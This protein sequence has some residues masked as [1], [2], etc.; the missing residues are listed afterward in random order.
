MTAP[1]AFVVGWP[2]AHSRSPLIHRFWLKR[3]GIDGD[4]VPRRFRRRRSRRFSRVRREGLCRR[5]RDAAA[6]GGGVPRLRGDDAGRA[7]PGGGEHAV[8]RRR[9]LHGDNTDVYG[10]VANLDERAPEWRSGSTALVIGAGG[11]SR[12][13]LQALID[14]G[15]SPIVVLNRTLARAEALARHFG[16][17]VS[18]GGLD[19]LPTCSPTRTSSSTRR[20]PACRRSGALDIPWRAA[21]KD[22]IAT[23]LVYVPLVT[24][25]LHGA[26]ERGLTIVDGLGMLL[27]QAVPGFERWFGVRPAV[28]A[29][30]RAHVVADIEG[31]RLTCASSASPDRSAWAR[32]RPPRCSPR[33]ACRC[34]MRTRPCIASIAARRSRRSRRRFRASTVDG[35]VDRARLAERVVGD[36][37]ALARLEAIVHPLVRESEEAFLAQRRARGTPA[38]RSSTSRCSSR[39]SA[40]DRVDMHRRRH[41]RRRKCSAPASWPG[42]A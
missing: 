1:K 2:I 5:Q 30:L 13:V 14:A 35:A 31:L 34:T 15:F 8:A 12:A 22:A 4:Y 21:K 23:D 29:E 37:A 6:Q 41:S 26:R 33:A 24:P 9:R 7:P 36:P 19:R 39:P 27:H 11:A 42:R 17:P 20:R 10:F 25:F 18:A 32:A 38:R 3:H 16:E 28:D 40:A